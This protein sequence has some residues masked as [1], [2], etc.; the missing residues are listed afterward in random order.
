MTRDI[1]LGLEMMNRTGV[2]HEYDG[3]IFLED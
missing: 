3:D 2:G 1:F